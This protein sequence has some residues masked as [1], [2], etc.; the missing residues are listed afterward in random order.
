M[1]PS[2]TPWGP[3]F[4]LEVGCAVCFELAVVE[5]SLKYRRSFGWIGPAHR[6]CGITRPDHLT[7]TGSGNGVQLLFEI[8][9]QLPKFGNR[10]L[11][12][13]VEEGETVDDTGEF[14]RL[15]SIHFLTLPETGF[16]IVDVAQRF[17]A[18]VDD[19]V[20]LGEGALELLL[21]ALFHFRNLVGPFIA[22]SFQLGL[23]VGQE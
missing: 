22:E 10:L 15:F 6:Y 19:F 3:A 23:L 11:V 16:D 1:R 20:H 12:L 18:V 5:D 7:R 17:F 8:P 9:V 4:L 13:F 2:R 14:L 21:V